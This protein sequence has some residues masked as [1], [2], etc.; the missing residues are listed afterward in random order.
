MSDEAPV[1]LE[2]FGDPDAAQCAD[3]VCA[4]TGKVVEEHTDPTDAVELES[5]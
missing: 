1:I 3:G 5:S 2:M 4:V